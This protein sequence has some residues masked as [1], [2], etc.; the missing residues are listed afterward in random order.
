MTTEPAV[1][2][3]IRE[4]V[5]EGSGLDLD[6]VRQGNFRGP[7]P[8]EVYAT[9]LLLDDDPHGQTTIDRQDDEDTG[10][11]S[12]LHVRARYS[13]QWY[14]QGA[15][16][17]ARRFRLWA[18]SELGLSHA[19][20]GDF[21][22]QFPIRLRRLDSIV[23]DQLEE[24]VQTDLVVDYTEK[25]TQLTGWVDEFELDVRRDGGDVTLTEEIRHGP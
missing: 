17:A 10:T 18:G 2:R 13:V 15:V 6:L 9:V 3:A 25:T 24:R 7:R 11:H 22:L 1:E 16:A 14:R 12:L 23:P 8:K 4:F 20:D 19:E 21:R 5:A